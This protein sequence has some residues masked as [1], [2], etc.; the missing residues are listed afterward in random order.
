MLN[1][2][3]VASKHAGTGPTQ[4]KTPGQAETLK[5]ASMQLGRQAYK[6]AKQQ[7]MQESQNASS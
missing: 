1:C 5:H 4:A 2:R 3:K 6:N 7:E